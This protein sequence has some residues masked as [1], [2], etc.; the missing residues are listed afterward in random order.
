LVA[1]TVKVYC[2][3]L[4]SPV[5]VRGLFAPEAV[6]VVPLV[7]VAV[8]VYEVTALPPFE[9]GGEKLTVAWALP[10]VTETFWGADGGATGAEATDAAG[11][12][13]TLFIALT[14]K[15]YVAE[16]DNPGNVYV[17]V[18]TCTVSV[19]VFVPSFMDT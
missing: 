18:G 4:T 13:P 10:A 8:T 3:P 9:A 16:L 2:V 6:T 5:T 12:V 7:G 15:V 14:E 17:V 1:V 11:P 19:V